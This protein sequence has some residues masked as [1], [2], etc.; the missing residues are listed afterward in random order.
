MK[1]KTRIDLDDGTTEIVQVHP[2]H[3]VAFEKASRRAIGG[4]DLGATDM[5]TLTWIAA[6]RPGKSF[7][8]WL[9]R[10]DDWDAIDDEDAGADPLAQMEH[11]GSS[12]P[13][14]SSPALAS[15]TPT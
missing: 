2:R 6:G 1:I 15:P 14:P 3:F 5:L 8:A 11:S 10:I 4:T 7:D 9:E 12:S 13:L